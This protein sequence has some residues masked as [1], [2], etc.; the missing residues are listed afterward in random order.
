MTVRADAERR[1]ERELPRL[2]FRQRQ[3]AYWACESFGKD[4]RL[5]IG[6]TAVPHHFDQPVRCLQRGL[7]GIVQPGAVRRPDDQSVD[8]DRDVM[9]LAPVQRRD[10]AEIMGLTI[11]PHP[12]EASLPHVVEQVP[13]FTLSPAN[14]RSKNFD[15]G[16]LGPAEHGVHD[17]SCTLPADGTPVV[18]AVRH[19]DA[20]PEQPQVVIDLGDCAHC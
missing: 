2:Q 18:R 10:G 6:R 13:E 19:P 8:D 17:L 11:D 20:G 16:F 9:V 12:D 7:Y 5:M 1:I 14:Q 15:A 3:S 4:D